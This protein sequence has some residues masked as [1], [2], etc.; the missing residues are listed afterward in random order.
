MRRLN[1]RLAKCR[2]NK[3]RYNVLYHRGASRCSH[4]WYDV[5]TVIDQS[6]TLRTNLELQF[7]DGRHY[8]I[9]L[10]ACFAFAYGMS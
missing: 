7:P 8:T 3:T 2:F 4:N 5:I 10:L 6:I 9:G 1:A